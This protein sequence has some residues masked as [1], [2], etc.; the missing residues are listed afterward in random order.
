MKKALAVAHRQH[1][2]R[3][4]KDTIAEVYKETGFKS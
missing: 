3:V 2:A 4:G 1:A